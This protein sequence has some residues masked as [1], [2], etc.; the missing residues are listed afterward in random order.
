MLAIL[1]APGN[2]IGLPVGIWA[3]AVLSHRE[4]RSAFALKAQGRSVPPPPPV[5]A[6]AGGAW[7]VVAVIV[8]GLILVLGVPVV[9]TL[10][11]IVVPAFYKSRVRAQIMKN[12]VPAFVVDGDVRDAVTGKLI[13]G[14]RVADNYYGASPKRAPQEAWT[15]ALGHYELKT[16]YEEHTI[17]ASAP[18]YQTSLATI[19][20]TLIH[21]ETGKH[22]DFQL[23]PTNSALPKLEGTPA[24]PA[25]PGS[26]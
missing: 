19:L 1:T 6:G 10:A 13:A 15:D 23:Q 20:T 21:P 11:S 14:A 8:A 16:W 17:A 9:A 25:P 12:Q 22:L 24:Q 2:L 7:K 18:G 5:T 3:L 4:I 26:P